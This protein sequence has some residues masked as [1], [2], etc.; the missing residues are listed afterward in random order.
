MTANHPAPTTTESD[1]LVVGAGPTGLLL[2]GD[3]AAAGLSVTVLERRPAGI[4]NLTRAFGVHARTLEQLDARGLADELLKTGRRVS[5]LG[6]FGS[7][8][9]DLDDLPS[10]FPFLLVTPQY[11]VER[12]LE[13]RAAEHG[14]RFV[15]G[16]EVTDVRQDA[17]GTEVTVRATGD[18]SG[19]APGAGAESGTGDGS[20]AASGAESGDGTGGTFVHRAPY[21]V[22]TDGHRSAVRRALGLPFPGK[23]V[24]RSMVLA[25]VRLD[26]PPGNG[27]TLNGVG[28]AF[29][30][31]ASYGD[32]WYRVG[33]WS[34]R[35]QVPDDTPVELGELRE[36]VRR[37]L[38]DDFGLHDA[39]WLSRFHSDERQVPAYRVGRVLL[40]GDAAHVHS[41]A[42]GQGMNTG[43]QDAANLGWK[44]A[45]VLRGE[46]PGRLLDTYHCERHPVGRT[47]L[48][49]SG[50]ILRLAM[51][52]NP[53]ELG[54]RRAGTFLLDRIPALR[55]KA[56]GNVTGIGIAYR[57]ARGERPPAG[58]RAPDLAVTS[59]DG[60]D[61][62]RLYEALRAGRHVLVGPAGTG[63][64][65]FGTGAAGPAGDGAGPGRVVRARWTD[66][67]RRTV[68]L[69][70]P[71]GYIARAAE[72]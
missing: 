2:A 4:S 60:A 40:A 12:L 43:L 30:F 68:L 65:F 49:S 19:A 14:V 31:V 10:R 35:R 20:G 63:P 72:A 61:F 56:V 46:A 55:R 38:G 33:G 16:A 22:G 54:I 69:V 45:A 71:D 58:R 41:P 47:V 32:G 52:D 62:G 24:I 51:A 7:L 66:P 64:G 21:T 17:A 59:P 28:D 67:G 18:G 1:A 34:R 36:N 8:S 5:R 11:E 70:R 44:L 13:R 39:R 42:G 25:D 6:L 29:A 27:V 15:Y 37:A 48:R 53:A 50:T 3:L 9:L 26:R 23:A 57:P